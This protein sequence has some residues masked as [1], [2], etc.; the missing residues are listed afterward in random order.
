MSSANLIKQLET[1]QQNHAAWVLGID[2]RQL[3]RL[4]DCPRNPDE[5]K[6]FN[7]R[8]IIRWRVQGSGSDRSLDAIKLQKEIEIVEQKTASLKRN[9]ERESQKFVESEDV[10]QMADLMINI[11]RDAATEIKKKIGDCEPLAMLLDVIGQAE[12]QLQRWK[13]G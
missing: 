8:D 5:A 6:S 9:N 7:V 11:Y 4:K 1:L 10:T 12:Q 13:Q 3:R 2:P